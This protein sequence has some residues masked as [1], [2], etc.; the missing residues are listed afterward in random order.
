METVTPLISD[1]VNACKFRTTA[2]DALYREK[3]VSV[4]QPTD[5]ST[6]QPINQSV[7]IFTFSLTEV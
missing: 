5:Q 7:T 6:N 2:S 4:N 3:T 1:K